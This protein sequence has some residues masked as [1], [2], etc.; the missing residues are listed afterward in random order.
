MTSN[1]KPQ[2]AK[3]TPNP[4]KT[5]LSDSSSSFYLLKTQELAADIWISSKFKQEIH[6]KE[7]SSAD[8]FTLDAVDSPF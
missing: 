6:F 7:L 2:P 4:Q 3:K 8:W 1:K 5:K